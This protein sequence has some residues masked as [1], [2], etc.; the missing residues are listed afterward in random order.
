[1]MAHREAGA[2]IVQT[3]KTA[4]LRRERRI[5]QGFEP[6]AEWM[7]R[8]LAAIDAELRVRDSFHY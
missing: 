8:R 4:H 1:M 5:I 3:M 2:Q 6:K 7:K